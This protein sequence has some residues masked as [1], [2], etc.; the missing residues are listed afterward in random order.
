MAFDIRSILEKHSSIPMER[1]RIV[2]RAED[3]HLAEMRRGVIFVFAA[4]SGPAHLGF[5]TFIQVLS[6]FVMSSLELVVLDIDCLTNEL[7]NQLFGAPGFTT[8]GYGETIWIKDG[9]VTAREMAKADKKQL[10]RDHTK[11]LLNDNAA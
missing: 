7:A 3:F 11:N 4:W 2:T 9:I 1:L 8:G 10:L 5:Q 6:E